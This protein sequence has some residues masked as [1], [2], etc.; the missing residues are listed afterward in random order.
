MKLELFN[1]KTKKLWKS[2]SGSSTH[3]LMQFEIQ[4]YRKLL[5]YFQ[6]GQS[7]FLIFNFQ[8]LT[9]DYISEEV[10]E[11]LGY[12]VK[13][14]TS[15]FLLE[16]VHPADRSWFLSCQEHANHF[17]MTL[18][19]DK[20]TKY[21]V[22]Y[23]V[24][25]KRQD[26]QYAQ[27]MLQSVVIQ[28]DND[29]CIIRT[30]TT[31][32]DISHIRKNEASV[33]SYIGMNSEPSYIDVDINHPAQKRKDVAELP[34]I[35]VEEKEKYKLSK[36]PHAKMEEYSVRLQN[37]FYNEKWHL[38]NELNLKMLSEKSNIPGHYVSQVINQC[39]KKSVSAYINSLRIDEFI[40]KLT[41]NSCNGLKIEF[42]AYM[43]GF[44]SKAAFY[45]LFKLHTGMTPCTYRSFANKSHNSVSRPDTF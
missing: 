6:P 42:I 7:C 44:N 40:H 38:N 33:L 43:C 1:S 13:G 36:L 21:K 17:F 22:Q 30:L 15:S 20:K 2:I 45:R 16:N 37:G 31:L 4:L 24:R 28:T 32:T 27:L 23:D 29:G 9:L 18:P 8:T 11:L 39:F 25:F 12:S 26:K 41:D 14:I 10:E 5:F 19:L 3:N 34:S 35:K